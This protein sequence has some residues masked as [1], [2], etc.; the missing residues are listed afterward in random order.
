VIVK[1][2]QVGGITGGG[3]RLGGCVVIEESRG[4]NG[5]KKVKTCRACYRG[6]GRGVGVR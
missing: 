3:D 1:E 6:V 4:V 5:F 2:E